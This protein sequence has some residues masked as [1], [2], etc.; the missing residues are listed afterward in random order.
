ML[1]STINNIKNMDNT[2]TELTAEQEQHEL[3]QFLTEL[4]EYVS[5][6]PQPSPED[7]ALYNEKIDFLKQIHAELKA[8]FPDFQPDYDPLA[9]SEPTFPKGKYLETTYKVAPFSSGEDE[10]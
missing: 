9:E 1:I 3:D 8:R 5:E 2:T 10:A 4:H 7:I 6:L